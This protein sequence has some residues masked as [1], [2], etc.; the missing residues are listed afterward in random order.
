MRIPCDVI[1]DLLPLYHDGVCSENSRKC[2]EEHL[3]E[4]P[5]CKGI[6]AEMDDAAFDD[7]LKTERRNIVSRH[8]KAVKRKSLVAGIGIALVL[9]V[10]VLITSIINIATGHALDW[11]FI[12]LTAIMMLAS[13]TVVPLVFE[14]NKWLWTMLCFTASLVLLLIACGIYTGGTW[15]GYWRTVLLVTPAC[16]ALPWGLFLIIGYMSANALT[17]TGLCV[18]FCGVFLSMIADVINWVLDGVFRVQLIGANLRI[19]NEDTINANVFMLVLLTACCIGGAFLAAGLLRKK[20][21]VLSR[22]R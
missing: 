16:L 6:L 2:V 8:T 10:P 1:T 9:A 11:F 12:V 17:K 7:L 19:W 4:C 13:I 3:A 18:V 15:H 5:A 20:A 21:A 14:K 22:R